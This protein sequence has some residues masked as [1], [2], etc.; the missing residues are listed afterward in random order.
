[1]K[2]KGT[3][4]KNSK[5]GPVT[6]FLSPE[7]YYHNFNHFKDYFEQ[8]ALQMYL[9]WSK[10]KKNLQGKTIY[11]HSS[12]TIHNLL[13]SICIN[14]SLIQ[15]YLQYIITLYIIYNPSYTM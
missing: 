1:M 13:N 12:Y 5:K 11:L 2:E 4:G 14:S 15:C 6:A 3:E 8:S 9:E 7:E 10:V